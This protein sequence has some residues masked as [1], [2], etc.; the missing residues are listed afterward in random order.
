MGKKVYFNAKLKW[1]K[2]REEDRD[3]GTNLPEGDQKTKI[4]GDQGHYIVQAYITADTKKEMVAKGVPTKGMVGQLFKEEDDGSLWYKCVRKHFNNKFVNKDTGEQG[5]VMGP[6]EVC[7]VIDGEKVDWDFEV[8]GL[9][10]NDTEAT[11][12]LDVWDGKIV[13]LEAIRV[14]SHVEFVPEN[15]EGF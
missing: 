13:T 2:V 9:L 4:E 14:D 12:K 5:V 8:D 10:G 6:P 3:M 11:I 1:S 7:R 15:T